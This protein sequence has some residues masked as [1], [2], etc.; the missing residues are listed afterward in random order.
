MNIGTLTSAVCVSA[1][2]IS[3]AGLLADGPP[4]SRGGDADSK[5]K[6]RTSI[7]GPYNPDDESWIDVGQ[8][9]EYRKAVDR[10]I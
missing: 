2:L 1:M 3:S 7:R 4:R 10:L 5:K 8:W 6:D 9:S